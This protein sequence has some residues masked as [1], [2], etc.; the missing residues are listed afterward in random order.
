[1]YMMHIMCHAL[2]LSAL[3]LLTKTQFLLITSESGTIVMFIEQMRK[4]RHKED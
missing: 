1:M 4:L 3:H 2:F